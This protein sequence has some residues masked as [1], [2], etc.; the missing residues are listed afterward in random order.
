MKEG[1]LNCPSFLL[2]AEA[3][4]LEGFGDLPGLGLAMTK[5]GPEPQTPYPWSRTF[6]TVLPWAAPLIRNELIRSC[7]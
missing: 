4:P 6:F 2:H 3:V 7:Y 1:S 5:L